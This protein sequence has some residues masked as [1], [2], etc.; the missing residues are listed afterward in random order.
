V[1]QPGCTL[2]ST[3]NAT[4]ALSEGHP[5]CWYCIHIPFLNGMSYKQRGRIFTKN[6][7]YLTISILFNKIRIENTVDNDTPHVYVLLALMLNL[8][9][10]RPVLW[11]SV[12]H[13][14]GI[15]LPI[16]CEC[17]FCKKN[18]LEKDR[19]VC[20]RCCAHWQNCTR[21]WQYSHAVPGLTICG[22]GETY[23]V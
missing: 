22:R 19:S 18:I 23:N 11:G 12:V 2:L 20:N 4:T 5:S 6:M 13:I 21:F 10:P 7:V 1:K 3:L 16:I 15:Y 14:S 9:K 8:S 17:S